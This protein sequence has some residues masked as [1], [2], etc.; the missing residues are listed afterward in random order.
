MRS[1]TA[2][3]T[4]DAAATIL[5]E[6]SAGS[7]HAYIA[8]LRSVVGHITRQWQHRPQ[9]HVLMH[10]TLAACQAQ[11]PPVVN[12]LYVSGGNQTAFSR[13]VRRRP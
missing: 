5:E 8:Q 3:R 9:G 4:V 12:P 1:T 6:T 10:G 11:Y 7:G 13:V 2:T